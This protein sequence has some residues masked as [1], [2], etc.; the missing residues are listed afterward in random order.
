MKR[1]IPSGAALVLVVTACAAGSTPAPQQNVAAHLRVA[2]VPAVAAARRA[3]A[4]RRAA[5]L[6]RRFAPPPGAARVRRVPPSD[7]LSR[8]GLGIS[9]V[10]ETAG[11]HAFWRTPDSQGS[12]VA[13]VKA[14][15]IRGLEWAGGAAS[16]GDWQQEFFSAHAVGGLPTQRML[17]VGIDRIGRWTFLRVDAGAAW[18]Y[19]RSRQEA[20]PAA[21]R[22]I[23]VRDHPTSRDVT[24]PVKVA[25]IIRSFDA[26]NVVQPGTEVVSCPLVLA[27]RVRFVFRSASGSRLATAAVPSRPATGCNPIAFSIGGTRQMQ[28]IDARVGRYSFI[29]RVERLLGVRFPDR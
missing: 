8:S 18:I 21:V 2:S 29:R 23:D 22:E 6:L 19:P 25:R 14:H 7:A 24:D 9:L 27:T 3:A 26:L 11:R 16:P 20:V 15:R 4:R 28:L 1:L 13:F 5:A 17:S 10:S 12:V